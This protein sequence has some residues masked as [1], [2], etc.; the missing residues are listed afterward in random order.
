MST[1]HPQSSEKKQNAR[2]TSQLHRYV[3]L[4]ASLFIVLIV[5]I[6]AGML[7]ERYFLSD[8]VPLAAHFQNL[9]AVTGI[10][11]D[12]Y[13]YRPSDPVAEAT[14]KAKLEQQAIGGMLGG[15]DDTYTRYL[16][17]QAA[18][19]AS[20]QLAGSYG[21]IGISIGTP[22][23]EVTI[24]AVLP[25][26]PG[27]GAGILPGDVI[28]AVDGLKVTV[29]SDI[30]AQIQGQVGT[31]VSLTLQRAGET[32]PRTLDVTRQKIVTLPVTYTMIP[33][34][35]YAL[36][37]IDIFGDQTTALVSDYL[38]QAESEH[39]AGI[40]LDLRG[41]GGGWVNSAQEVIGRFVP[42]ASG[43]ALYEDPTLAAGGEVSLPIVNGA[44]PVYSGPLVVLVDGGTASAAEIV[45][46]ALRDYDRAV[47]VGRETFGKGSVQRI[48]DF[49]D[50]AS[51]RVTVAEWL[52]PMKRPIQV[53]GISPDVEVSEKA[54]VTTG[55]DADLA[56]A[57]TLLNDGTSRPSEL[58]LPSPAASPAASSMAASATLSSP[59]ASPIAG[60]AFI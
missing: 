52:T 50:G 11:E 44:E 59:D 40:V 9:D 17:P 30:S 1:D 35:T 55:Q 26:G 34:T 36:I 19:T 18:T 33:E 16:E 45:A 23:N 29:G 60:C 56:Q 24:T 3:R 15:L 42:S 53:V 8:S 4:T 22:N 58:S 38:K 57:I 48:Y 37:R 25:A 43:P 10:I 28:L 6:T 41:N 5:G 31:R 27:A 2:S 49:K 32:T 13:Y 14:W 46:G 7:S 54:H 21:G 12:D 20:N 39:A 47:V 51:M